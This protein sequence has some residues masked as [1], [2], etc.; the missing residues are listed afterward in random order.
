[1]NR[2]RQTAVG[3]LSCARAFGARNNLCG[4][5]VD[6]VDSNMVLNDMWDADIIRIGRA[7]GYDTLCFTASLLI[8]GS[9]LVDLRFYGG[10]S[11]ATAMVEAFNRLGRVSLRNP[12]DL[13]KGRPCNFTQHGPTFRMACPGHVSWELRNTSVYQKQCYGHH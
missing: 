3:N 8:G 1:V 5:G 9:E 11:D 6:A 10:Q 13:S 2:L 12:L 4:M 7:L